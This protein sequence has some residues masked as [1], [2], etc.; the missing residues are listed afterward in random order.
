MDK[1]LIK[2]LVGYR[3]GFVYYQIGDD[4][5]RCDYADQCF[6]SL[7]WF[8]TRSA[9]AVNIKAYGPLF[10]GTGDEA[11]IIHFNP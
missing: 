7:R 9:M 11:Q 8:S 6:E 2:T 3:N 10:N 4:I 1:R 5:F